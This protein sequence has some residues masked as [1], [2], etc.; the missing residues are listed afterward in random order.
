[1]FHIWP[2][3]LLVTYNINLNVALFAQILEL[4]VGLFELNE[5]FWCSFGIFDLHIGLA[6]LLLYYL[7]RE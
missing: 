5:L 2:N 7:F 4:D 3:I 6:Y 1:M